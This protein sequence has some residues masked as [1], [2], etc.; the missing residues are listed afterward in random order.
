LTRFIL[1]DP[2]A[3]VRTRQALNSLAT[4][5]IESIVSR[6]NANLAFL[7]LSLTTGL[8][9]YTVTVTGASVGDIVIVSPVGSP[10]NSVAS[11][12]GVVSATDT[13]KIRI[14]ISGGP[15]GFFPHPF[16]VTVLGV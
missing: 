1:K 14:V 11:W 8:A 3:S 13:V 4:S 9:E 5:V 6:V 10:P 15:G 7:T 12:V 16:L 2:T